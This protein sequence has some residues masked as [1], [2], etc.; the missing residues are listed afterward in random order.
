MAS[1]PQFGVINRYR[2]PFSYAIVAAPKLKSPTSTYRG[3]SVT[4]DCGCKNTD[5][6]VSFQGIDCDS[7]ARQ[8]MACIDR[9]LA[10]PGRCNAFWEYFGKK[11]S[12]GSG[13]KPDELFLIHSNINQVRE[14]FETWEDREALHL[15][16]LLE[17][18]CC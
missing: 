10:L 12:G 17:E 3:T 9:H 5:R 2:H 15:L 13:P 8:I 11:R 16:A 4:L 14:L 7:N 6:Y 18:E 1:A